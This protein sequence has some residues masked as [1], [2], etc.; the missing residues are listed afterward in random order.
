MDRQCR[1]L[2]HQKGRRV[3]N[4]QRQSGVS[5]IELLIGIAI[6]GVLIALGAPAY[7]TWLQNAQIRTAAD[8]IQSGLQVAKIEAIRRNV[9]MRFAL[10]DDTNSTSS[11]RVC[12]Y[13]VADPK[14]LIASTVVQSR[15]GS[16]GSA[17]VQIGAD[18]VLGNL[19]T[20]LNPGDGLPGSISFDQFGRVP[21]APGGDL[22]RID[23][24]NPKISASDERRLDLLVNS[25]GQIRFCDPKLSLATNP[26]GC[27]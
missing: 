18:D 23:V 22:V 12:T 8:S 19:L 1:M 17:N 27:V 14:C 13:N 11:W 16:E 15:T 2:G 25:S 9:R 6:F 3:L 24:R 4:P 21:L 5:L 7:R 20:P 10:W 26:Q